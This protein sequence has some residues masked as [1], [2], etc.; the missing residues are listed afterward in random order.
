MTYEQ[1]SARVAEHLGVPATHLRFAPVTVSTGKA[2]AWIKRSVAQ[3]L[4]QILNSQYSAYGY[5][6]HRPDALYYE[7]L[8]SSLSEYEMKK[9]VKLNWLPD[10]ISKEVRFMYP[11]LQCKRQTNTQTATI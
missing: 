1:F 7:V 10:G 2:K 4:G 9:I 8:E 3:T 5:A 11:H 6:A